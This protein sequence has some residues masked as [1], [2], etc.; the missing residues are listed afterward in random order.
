MGRLPQQSA[1]YSVDLHSHSTASDGALAPEALVLHAS[2]QGVT[3]L[4][5]TDHDTVAGIEPARQA[6]RALGL[7]LIPGVEL[8]VLWEKHTIHIVGLG[9]RPDHPALTQFMDQVRQAR[10]DRAERICYKL[11]KL[12]VNIDWRAVETHSIGRSHIA[13]ALVACGWV[14]DHAKAFQYY[15]K[16]GKK[17]YVKAQWPALE[18]G[19]AAILAAGGVAVLAHP[20]SYRL[21][22]GKLNRLLQAFRGAG[23]TAIEVITA[24]HTHPNDQGA[25]ARARRFQLYA[26]CGSDF[27]HPDW[28]WRQLGRL[29]KLPP[30]LTPVWQA[31]PLQHY[32]RSTD[33]T[34]C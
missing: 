14:K 16:M 7:T 29:A 18:E 27:H 30:D 26:S 3:H 2:N 21:S 11:A 23:G 28:R 32:F 8:S 12:G 15:L 17:A 22:N 10:Q 31:P 25:A 20:G 4:A 24:A 19:V 5:L 1:N 6:A 33:G 13:H 9:I 34:H